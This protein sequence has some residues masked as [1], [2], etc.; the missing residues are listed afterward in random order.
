MPG[1]SP[2]IDLRQLQRRRAPL[3]LAALVVVATQWCEFRQPAGAA[4]YEPPAATTDP[5]RL[6]PVY[7]RE[8]TFFIPFQ[9][10]PRQFTAGTMREVRLLA[11]RDGVAWSTLQQARPEVR[12]FSYRAPGDGEYFFAVQIADSSGRLNPP[13]VTAPQLRI[14]VDATKPQIEAAIRP[15]VA[16]SA[17]LQ[18]DLRDSQLDPRTLRI[19]VSE[20][21]GA[22]R[23]VQVG[24]AEVTRPDRLMGS[25]TW[26]AASRESD[27]RFR[28]AV[29][30]RAGTA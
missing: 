18:Y 9:P 21:G 28:I 17:T 5:R 4:S 8:P 24:P 26:S 19:E 11:S 23:S 16:G 12:G 3:R 27:L 6:E 1:D 10:D 20:D 25:V 15:A 30:D 2:H 22:W 29:A 13:T 14:V 7:W